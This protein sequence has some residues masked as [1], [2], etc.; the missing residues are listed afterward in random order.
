MSPVNGS[1]DLIGF[2][3]NHGELCACLLAFNVPVP[4]IAQ[5][6]EVSG[7]LCVQ[8]E[9]GAPAPNNGILN[10]DLYIG[11]ITYNRQR[12]VKDPETAKRVARTNPEHQW[13]TREV[14]HLRIVDGWGAWVGS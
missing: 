13:V 1:I 3:L 12:F 10:N 9:L 6:F 5:G 2:T 7:V 11:R 8:L 4:V 14:P